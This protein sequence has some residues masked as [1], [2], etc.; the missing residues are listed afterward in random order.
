MSCCGRVSCIYNHPVFLYNNFWLSESDAT[1]AFTATA[2]SHQDV[3]E[4]ERYVFDNVRTNVGGWYNSEFHE[5]T[6]P[7]DGY[8]MF[9]FTLLSRRTFDA[10]GRLSI[11]GKECLNAFGDGRNG[12]FG[13]A[14]GVYIAHCKQAERVWVEPISAY[15]GHLN[16]N[17]YSSFS[18]MLLKVSS[19]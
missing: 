8:Y 16:G 19:E 13:S 5:F 2:S 14:T 18:G 17:N 12:D 4:G 10:V 9:S 1:I 6:C 7:L 15:G 11:E 3:E